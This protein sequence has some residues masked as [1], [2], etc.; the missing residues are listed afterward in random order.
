MIHLNFKI[1]C[2]RESF[3][4]IDYITDKI[5]C[6]EDSFP[7]EKGRPSPPR[8]RS[9]PPPWGRLGGCQSEAPSACAPR[10]GDDPLCLAGARH[11]PHGGGLGGA[12]LGMCLRMPMG[13]DVFLKEISITVGLSSANYIARTF[14]QVESMSQR[15]YQKMVRE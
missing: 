13:V 2:L 7:L 6:Q 12:S 11:L 3:V 10:R 14:R 9:A 15:E 4:Y 5:A 8:W 1:V